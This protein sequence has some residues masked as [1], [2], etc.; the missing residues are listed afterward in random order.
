MRWNGPTWQAKTII[1]YSS[2][3]IPLKRDFARARAR[4]R[5]TACANQ[6][7]SQ[8]CRLATNQRLKTADL[9]RRLK[10][11]TKTKR[12][13]F[14]TRP[15]AF[16]LGELLSSISML[17]FHVIFMLFILL[18]LCA[19]VF[20]FQHPI[21]APTLWFIGLSIAACIFNTLF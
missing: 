1:S 12:A 14:K 2:P 19:P 8:D 10:I 7:A 21:R 4:D 3:L 6:S 11:K 16:G 17:L 5:N 20:I 15:P 13:G 9:R 18:M